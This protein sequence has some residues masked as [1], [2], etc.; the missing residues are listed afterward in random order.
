VPGCDE[1]PAGT[2]D[3]LVLDD[4]HVHARL[5]RRRAALAEEAHGMRPEPRHTRQIRVVGAMESPAA[6]SVGGHMLIIPP[7]RAN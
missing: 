3:A 6:V 2:S 4:P 1:V 5:T 7:V